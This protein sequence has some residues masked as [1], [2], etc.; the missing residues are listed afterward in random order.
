M[1]HF[2]FTSY[3]VALSILSFGQTAVSSYS[4]TGNAHDNIGDNDGIVQGAVLTEDRFGNPNSAYQ[5]DGVDDYINFGD[6]SEFRF[7]SSYS[8]STWVYIEDVLGQNIGTILVKRNP[9]SPYNQYNLSVTS[10]IQ[11]GGNGN[12]VQ[13]LHKGDI[14]PTSRVLVSPNLTVGWHH[15]VLVQNG[16]DQIIKMYFDNVLVATTSYVNASEQALEVLGNPFEIGG[17]IVANNHFK[18]KIDDVS[19]YQDT[20]S[21]AAVADLYYQNDPVNCLVA[22]YTF[23]NS[24]IADVHGL[25]DANLGGASFGT[26]NA[27]NPN[28]CLK[29]DGSGSNQIPHIRHQVIDP[30]NDFTVAYWVNVDSINTPDGFQYFVTSRL[31]EMGAE[32]GG[33]DMGIN[34]SG[35]FTCVLRTSTSAAI[36]AVYSPVQ[37][38]NEWHH[39]VAV[40]ENDSLKFYVDN[41]LTGTDAIGAA[42]MNF[43]DYWSLGAAYSSG[44]TIVR[45][46][47]GRLDDI[48]FYCRALDATE[49]S[50]LNPLS[51]HK[52][53][54]KQTIEW[55]AYPNPVEDVLNIS[56][57]KSLDAKVQLL[58]VA[59][60]SLYQEVL[61]DKNHQ[62]DIRHLEAGIYFLQISTENGAFSTQKIIKK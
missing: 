11:F 47:S 22:Q 9:N 50:A 39:I 57:E 15:I 51:T 46:L 4:F 2:L 59:G 52:I 17:N 32:Q 28:S 35:E 38:T 31:N 26:D 7:T 20:L 41:T 45:E 48:R 34:S 30:N 36:A 21:A 60:Q 53:A 58:N 54:S 61:K 6:S 14:M 56:L 5:F 8:F 16:V 13:F 40:R 49:I 12:T 3:L 23:D 43:P 55:T 27:G 62:L 10:D 19:I 42:T 44:P 25:R 37:T 24:S 1:K 29:I 18:G 33:L